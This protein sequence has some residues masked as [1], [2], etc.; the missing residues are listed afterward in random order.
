MFRKGL[1]NQIQMTSRDPIKER[2]AENRRKGHE[3]PT[4][5]Q[6]RQ[7]SASYA[8]DSKVARLSHAERAKTLLVR[9]KTGFLATLA[10]QDNTPFGSIVNFATD[11]QTGEV[12]FIASKLAEHTANLEKNPQASL[13]VTEEQVSVCNE[14]W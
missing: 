8:T 12:F 1:R 13:L 3:V 7:G 14:E 11:P 6:D 2:L 4:V 10:H 9:Q 5:L